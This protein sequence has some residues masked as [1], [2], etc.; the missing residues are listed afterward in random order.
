[1]WLVG[2][3]ALFLLVRWA[4]RDRHI[5][6]LHLNTPVKRAAGIVLACSVLLFA[7]G[8]V[9]LGVESGGAADFARRLLQDIFFQDRWARN[10]AWQVQY[11]FY[12]VLTG[13]LFSYCYD[14]SI[15][16]MFHWVRKG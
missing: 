15:G 7:V 11:G 3:L 6:S 10:Y 9:Q 16:R 13:L 4:W 12:G 8:L 5:H 1:M 14:H 2:A